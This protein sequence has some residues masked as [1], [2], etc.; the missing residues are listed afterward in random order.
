MELS[1]TSDWALNPTHSRPIW[2]CVGCATCKY[3]DQ[4]SNKY[5][6]SPMSLQVGP[7]GVRIYVA[8]DLGF[9]ICRPRRSACMASN[10]EGPSAQTSW[11]YVPQTIIGTVLGAYY[12]HIW[13]LHMAWSFRFYEYSHYSHSIIYFKIYLNMILVILSDN[14]RLDIQVGTSG[15]CGR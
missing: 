3:R 5:L 1:N 2:R 11:F 7:V 10:P 9:K 6:R 4:L 13:V 8:Y 12:L 15:F 14:H